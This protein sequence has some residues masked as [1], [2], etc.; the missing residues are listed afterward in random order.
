[1]YNLLG[2]ISANTL[3]GINQDILIEKVKYWEI[4]M[5]QKELLQKI[6]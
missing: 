5:I 1:M 4:V 3:K 6:M 2:Y